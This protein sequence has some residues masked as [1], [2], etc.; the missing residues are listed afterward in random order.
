V[1]QKLPKNENILTKYSVSICRVLVVEDKGDSGGPKEI[2]FYH[3]TI[4]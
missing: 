1:A 4:E 3:V 2:Y